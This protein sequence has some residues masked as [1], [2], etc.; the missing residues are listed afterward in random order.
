MWSEEFGKGLIGLIG[1]IFFAGV[2]VGVMLCKIIPWLMTHL[3]IEWI[4]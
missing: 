4:G 3:R 2:V 1:I